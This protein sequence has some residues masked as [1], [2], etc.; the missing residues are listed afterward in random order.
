MTL[1]A[2]FK[3][4]EWDDAR[5]VGMMEAEGR[6]RWRSGWERSHCLDGVT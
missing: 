4:V 3:G 1:G 2:G 5:Q 6:G